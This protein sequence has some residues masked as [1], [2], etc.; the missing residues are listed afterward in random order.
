MNSL[1]LTIN[2]G[3]K[4]SNKFDVGFNID[5]I[6][7][8]FEVTEMS[9]YI[10]NGKLVLSLASPTSLNLLLIG[11]NDKGSLNS[12]LFGRYKL[13]DHLDLKLAYRYLFNESTTATIIQTIPS[14]ND[15]F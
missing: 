6:G 7:I 12:H 8:S 15:R 11:D 3:Y 14:S 9:S 2:L 4:I 5:A 13:C 1:N 10:K